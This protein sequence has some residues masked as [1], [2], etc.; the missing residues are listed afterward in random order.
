MARETTLV[1]GASSGIGRDLAR[2]FAADGHHLVLVA[3]NVAALER[4][5]DELARAHGVDARILPVDLGE[6]GASRRHYD[7]LD[8]EHVSVDVV[9]NNAGFGLQGAFAEHTPERIAEMIQVNVAAVTELTRLFL[10]AM[11]ARN[12]GGFLNV[13]ST[14]AFQPGPFMA[15]YYATKA[16]VLSFTEAI[17]EVVSGTELRIR[18]LAPGPT[19]TGFAEA[20]HMSDTALFKRVGTMKSIDVA[21]IGYAGWKRRKTIVI[22][23]ATNRFGASLVRVSPR[24]VVRKVI[25]RLN[26]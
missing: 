11:L 15:V 25:R 5:A 4:L 16:Y 10:P 7:Q 6:P 24:A 23:G 8:R 2:E 12:R 26:T 18:C 9:V 20:A 1:T 19:A 22:P 17:A 14:A 21:R 13:A 3:R